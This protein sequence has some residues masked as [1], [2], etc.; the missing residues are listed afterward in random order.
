MLRALLSA[1]KECGLHSGNVKK[2]DGTTEE[3][4]AERDLWSESSAVAAL[5]KAAVEKLAGGAR[6]K[7]TLLVLYAPW[8]PFCQVRQ[9]WGRCCTCALVHLQRDQ[10][11]ASGQCLGVTALMSL[12]LCRWVGQQYGWSTAVQLV[13]SSMAV[14]TLCVAGTAL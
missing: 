11:Q 12:S 3:R 8:C 14:S 1:A 4:K 9:G 5:D 7:D 2:A 13:E 6:D 10:L